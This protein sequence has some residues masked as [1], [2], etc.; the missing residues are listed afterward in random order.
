MLQEQNKRIIIVVV[1][2]SISIIGI[3]SYNS[4]KDY[5]NKQVLISWV[6]LTQHPGVTEKDNNLVNIVHVI[7]GPKNGKLALQ[8]VEID[9]YYDMELI[10]THFYRGEARDIPW[11]GKIPDSVKSKFSNIK[12][13]VLTKDANSMHDYIITTFKITGDSPKGSFKKRVVYNWYFIKC[14]IIR[15]TEPY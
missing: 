11:F 1:I 6:G 14:E 4:L 13:A 8:E 2:I 12:G 10:E 5:A 9:D 15:E 3:L 7:H